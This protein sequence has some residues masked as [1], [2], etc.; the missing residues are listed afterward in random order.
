MAAPLPTIQKWFGKLPK[1]D[2]GP[3]RKLARDWVDTHFMFSNYLLLVFPLL[4][5]AGYIPAHLGT[6]LSTKCGIAVP[7]DLSAAPSS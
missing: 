4:L 1:R 2:K 6:Y 5:V 3:V 7:T